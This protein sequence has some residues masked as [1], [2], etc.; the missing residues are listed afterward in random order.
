[1]GDHSHYINWDGAHSHNIGYSGNLQLA[2]YPDGNHQHNVA[3]NGGGVPMNL[4]QPVIVVTKIIYA[5]SQA[6]PATASTSTTTSHA[7]T[8]LDE[9]RGEIAELRALL[10]APRAV[11]RRQTLSSP[12]RGVH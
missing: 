8:E 2:I 6:A 12:L 9:L 4:T 10:L 11:P 3:L 7:V 5:G 1:V